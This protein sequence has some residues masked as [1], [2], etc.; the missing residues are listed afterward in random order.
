MEV[1]APCTA[2]RRTEMRV[3]G[4]TTELLEKAV[5]EAGPLGAEASPTRARSAHR[6]QLSQ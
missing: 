4:E 2:G 5:V 3:T 6:A 1:Q